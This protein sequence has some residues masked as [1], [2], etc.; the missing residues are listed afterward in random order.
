MA[1]VT[2]TRRTCL[3]LFPEANRIIL[4]IQNMSTSMCNKSA[5]FIFF[6]LPFI[7]S[8]LL[9]KKRPEKEKEPKNEILTS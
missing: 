9:N 7:C 4:F 1:F 6:I 5:L 2:S 8:L 3:K